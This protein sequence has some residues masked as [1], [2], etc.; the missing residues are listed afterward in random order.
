MPQTTK[1]RRAKQS[2]A[3][4][5]AIAEIDFRRSIGESLWI[6]LDK[7]RA[8]EKVSRSPVATPQKDAKRRRM[9]CKNP[10]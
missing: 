2:T 7:S 5:A 3:Q 8:N 4:N 9:S 6:S 10:L 1:K